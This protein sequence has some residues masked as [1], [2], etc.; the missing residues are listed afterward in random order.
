[1]DGNGRWAKARGLSRVAGHRQG[2]EALRRSVNAAARLG[3]RYMTVFGF[4][5]ENWRRPSEEVGHLMALLRR[6]LLS[7]V[8]N[9]RKQGVRLRAIGDWQRLP[10]EIA[11]LLTE[12]EAATAGQERLD[13]IIALSYGGR[14]ELMS[15][16]RRLIAAALDG[17]LKPEE[18]DELRFRGALQLP[19]VPDPELIIR[20]SGEQRLSNFLLWQAAHSELVFVDCLWPD[21]GE[22]QLAAALEVYRQRQPEPG[23]GQ[24]D[25][26]GHL[27]R[28]RAG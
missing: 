14:Q 25:E 12:A 6:F 1:M 4:S 23:G 21:F 27:R 20:T 22:P 3:L 10:S 28:E 15:A 26:V 2:V 18:I 5:T 13:L 9:L 7:E 11:E 8:K 17:G 19:D 24:G 16:A